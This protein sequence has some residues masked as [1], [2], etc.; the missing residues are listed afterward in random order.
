MT[1]SASALEVP[2]T[3]KEAAGVVRVENPVNSGVPLPKG[4]V[5]DAS[6]LRVVD[7][8]NNYV[9]ASI[10]PRARWLG[11]GSIKWVTVHFLAD[12]A[13]KG[14]QDYRL[15]LTNDP[16]LKTE[17]VIDEKSQKNAIVVATG[18]AKFVVPTDKFAP[19]SQVYVQTDPKKPIA[20]GDSLLG[21][22]GSVTL[23]GRNGESKV[24][25]RPGSDGEFR[26][27]FVAVDKGTFTQAA[28]VQS[29]Q[30]EERGPGRA[31]IALKGTF[32]TRQAKSLDFTA[33]LYFYSGSSLVQMTFSVINR[34]MDSFSRFVG[35]ERLAIEL[36][37]K[38]GDRVSF[39]NNGGAD[40][41]TPEQVTLG[42]DG[43]LF[44]TKVGPK[45]IRLLQTARDK[46]TITTAD[47]RKT[48]GATSDGFVQVSGANGVFTGGT[49][50]FWQV[51]PMGIAVGPDG[52]VAM[53]IK[54]ADTDRVDLYT[55][56]SKTHFVFFH[57]APACKV[58]VASM[59]AGTT[60]PL[61]AA[62][63][64]DWYCQD[65]RVMGD[66]FSA[67]PK[68]Y[69]PKYR[70]LIAAYQKQVDACMKRIVD[71]RPR[72]GWKVDEFG[73]LNFGAGLHHRDYV[74]ETAAESW[75]DANYYDFPHAAVVNFLR[76]G[77]LL[78]LTTA[79]EAGLHLADLDICH[80][81]PGRP[82]E[83]GQPRSGPVV[84]HFR[85]Y[86]SG[87]NYEGHNSFTFYKNESLYELYY[88]TGERW[89]HEV[90]LMSSDF[91][92]ARYG[93]GALRNLAHGIWGVLSAYQDTQQPKYLDR[94][95]FFVDKWGKPWQD[96]YNG[97][98][99]DQGWMYGLAFEAY[100]KYYRLTNDKDTAAYLVK[101]LDALIGEFWKPAGG[102]GGTGGINL[103][104]YGLGYEYTGNQDYLDKGL[105]IL[106]KVAATGEGG[107]RVKTFAQN[108]RA[109]PYFLKYLTDGYKPTPFLTPTT[110]PATQEN[111]AKP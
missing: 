56:G 43:K 93:Q 79:E 30:V 11:D 82:E 48:A 17:L 41:G 105:I 46:M 75:W 110:H 91:A 54:P 10:E 8:K 38:V 90:A 63:S 78:N 58:P 39:F 2:F 51:Y 33:R 89:Y 80:S 3:V 16:P 98:F 101:A 14:Q 59:A 22:P 95:K 61:V 72:P 1:T 49:R 37:L 66:L 15:I 32:S 45:P 31:V 6:Q 35:I 71:N 68:L 77:D 99:H 12:L 81:S 106:K 62:C 64:P 83:V 26:S 53:E 18:P 103:F 104:G 24:V 52:S 13:A 86:T 73:W 34:Q 74:R 96:K 23:V 87:Q 28:V 102:T 76:T 108:F 65:T 94:A 20:E 50:W 88:L 25:P 84:G 111:G 9:L 60:R 44:E 7:A 57:F 36:P 69:D 107:D 27:E 92:M 70:D 67:N 55:A 19:F 85:N 42:K 29:A 4:E 5:K 100:D 47:G 21:K 109:S 40:V 97:S